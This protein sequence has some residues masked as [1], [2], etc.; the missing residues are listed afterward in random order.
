[1]CREGECVCLRRTGNSPWSSMV[2][3]LRHGVEGMVHCG[4][5]WVMLV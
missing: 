3:G 1:M 4:G 2:H 5:W